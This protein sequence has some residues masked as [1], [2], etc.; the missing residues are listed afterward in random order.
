MG[1]LTETQTLTHGPEIK[2][3]ALHEKIDSNGGPF[4]MDKI[5]KFGRSPSRIPEES[6]SY[7]SSQTNSSDDSIVTT[8][9]HKGCVKRVQVNFSSFL[10][11]NSSVIGK[12]IL[13]LLLIGY[14]VY[15]AF[16]VKRSVDGSKALIILT[17][18]T[19][20]CI[21]YSFIRDAF[22]EQIYR[23][24]FKPIGQLITGN[25]FCIKW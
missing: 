19:I 18:I 24:I 25:W 1:T 6:D 14:T 12:I 8:E 16:A 13:F 11:V 15:F 7:Q 3:T 23:R 20:Y 10:N 2:E 5:Q 21:I 9:S 17:C 4:G 22:G